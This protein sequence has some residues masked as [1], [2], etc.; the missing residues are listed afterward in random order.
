MLYHIIN[1]N[2]QYVNER[3]PCLA[4]LQEESYCVSCRKRESIKVNIICYT[5]EY[6]SVNVITKVKRTKKQKKKGTE[7][8]ISESHTS[9]KQVYIQGRVQGAKP[10]KGPPPP[11][12]KVLIFLGE[13]EGK[14]VKR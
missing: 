2:H 8:E 13:S 12:P 6:D 4:G 1:I 10:E 11:P 5:L 9:L 7:N 14:E 3:A